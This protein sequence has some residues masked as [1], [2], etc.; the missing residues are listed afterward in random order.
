MTTGRIVLIVVGVVV[1]IGL[2][3]AVFVG[4]IVGFALYS[5]SHSE[6]AATAKEFLKTSEKL[7]Q[8]IGDVKDF[9][10]IVSGSINIRNDNGEATLHLKVIGEK[11]TVNASVN[12][13]F[14][15]GRTWRVSSASYVNDKGQTVTLFDPY[16]SK[17]SIPL[18][19]A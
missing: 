1:V 12:L 16:D 5:V 8:D 13:I 19:V 18:P 4:G 17:R 9:G 14:L 2:L 15:N 6:A 3:V 11:E 7:K 10:T